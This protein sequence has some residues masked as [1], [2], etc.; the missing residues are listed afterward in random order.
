MKKIAVTQRLVENLGYYEL[1]EMLDIRWA[2]LLGSIDLLPIILPYEANF[3]E[4]FNSIDIEGVLLTGGNDLSSVNDD[5]VSHL[6]DNFETRLLS[7]A[8]D[9]NIPVYGVC[10]GMQL[11][12]NYFSG[13]VVEI[14]DHVGTT[15][16]L[17]VNKDSKYFDELNMLDKVNSFQNY[18]V[19]IVG[20]NLIVSAAT[21]DGVI[22]AI[23]H[24]DYKI[25]AQMWHSERN[26]PFNSQELKFIQDF[27]K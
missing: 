22:K 25:F 16:S 2:K 1:R 24:L 6:R 10:R 19:S 14:N 21:S 11:I 4:Y 15:H 8:I 20:D 18:A 23:E 17:L 9:N 3:L 5:K 26:D 12:N 7:F 27:F 13:E